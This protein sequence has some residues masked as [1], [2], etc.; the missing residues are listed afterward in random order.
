MIRAG[1]AKKAGKENENEDWRSFEGDRA[2]GEQYP[3]L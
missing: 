2:F 1:E 3:F